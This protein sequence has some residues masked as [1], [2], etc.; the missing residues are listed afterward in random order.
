MRSLMYDSGIQKRKKDKMAFDEQTGTWKR[1][2]GYD[3]VNDD[4]DIPIIEAKATDG[5]ISVPFLFFQPK[6]LQNYHENLIFF[7]LFLLFCS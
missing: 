6:M 7:L 2:H 1:L 5:I 4:N 3:R